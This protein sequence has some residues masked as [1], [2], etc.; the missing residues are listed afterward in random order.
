M[1][2]VEEFRR[3]AAECRDLSAKAASPDL[4]SHFQSLSSVWDR[5]AE[6]RMTYFV[7]P[8]AEDKCPERS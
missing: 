3:R 1:K 2:K 6:E 5:L 4:R 8:E 7:D